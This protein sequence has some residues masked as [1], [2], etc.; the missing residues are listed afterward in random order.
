MSEMEIV[1][2]G[3]AEQWV[4]NW[5]SPQNEGQE[6][7]KQSILDLKGFWVPG[8]DLLNVMREAGAYNARSYLNELEDGSRQ[9]ASTMKTSFADAF[10]NIARN[11][12]ELR[13]PV[14]VFSTLTLSAR[15]DASSYSTDKATVLT[16]SVQLPVRSAAGNVDEFE[17]K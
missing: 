11:E 16:M 4:N 3:N 7:A 13:C 12:I 17:L 10:K 2:P 14:S 5:R 6:A 8:Q 1:P 15:P 9:L